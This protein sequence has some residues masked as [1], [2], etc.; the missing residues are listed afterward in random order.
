MPTAVLPKHVLRDSPRSRRF[1]FRGWWSNRQR[2]TLHSWL[3]WPLF[4]R[5]TAEKPPDVRAW[6][7]RPRRDRAGNGPTCL[8]RDNQSARLLLT[9]LA[10]ISFAAGDARA[11]FG[12]H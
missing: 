4:A 6:P 11:G 7:E 2:W 5:L 10:C 12:C 3:G 9:V 1:R 8:A